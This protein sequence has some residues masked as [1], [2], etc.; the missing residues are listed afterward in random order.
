MDYPVVES[1]IC[2]LIITLLTS[3]SSEQKYVLRGVLMK[4]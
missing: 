3:S 2:S 1:S 4:I